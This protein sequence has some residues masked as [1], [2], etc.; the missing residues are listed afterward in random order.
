MAL[1]DSFAL[2]CVLHISLVCSTL[3]RHL[4]Q[5]QIVTAF[6]SR[7]L[8]ELVKYELGSLMAL[9]AV[10]LNRHSTSLIWLTYDVLTLPVFLVGRVLKILSTQ[11]QDHLV[12]HTVALIRTVGSKSLVRSCV[13]IL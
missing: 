1:P 11:R 13:E 9:L 2:A 3:E 6:A 7:R 10:V 5:V 12:C 8:G 4:L